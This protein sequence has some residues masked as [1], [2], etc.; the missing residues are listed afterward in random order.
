MAG[1]NNCEVS[2]DISGST[3]EFYIK[4]MLSCIGDIDMMQC[5][6][7]LLAIP[8]GD[9]PPTELPAHLQHV[10]SV[11]E[12]INSHQPGFVYLKLSYILSKTATAVL[13]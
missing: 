2:C 12:I 4:P 3:A 1:S 11:Y 8:A 5:Y 7:S 13:L 6:N 10:V 9:T